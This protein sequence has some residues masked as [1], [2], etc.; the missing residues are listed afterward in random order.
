MESKDGVIVSQEKRT[1]KDGGH[2]FIRER[3]RLKTG[4][5]FHTKKGTSKDAV[6]ISHE[7]K[8]V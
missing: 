1:S 5:L 4:S 7:K 6:I 8:N 2:Y 3:Q